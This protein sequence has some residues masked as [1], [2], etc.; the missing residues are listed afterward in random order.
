MIR[1]IIKLLKETESRSE[2]IAQAKGINKLP[3][4]F[5]EIKRHIKLRYK[6]A[7]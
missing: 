1:D 4:N 6:F 2:L 7:K 5:R 3:T